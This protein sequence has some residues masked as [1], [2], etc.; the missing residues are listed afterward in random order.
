MQETFLQS[1][2]F[3]L[4]VIIHSMNVICLSE[5]ANKILKKN[6]RSQGYTLIEIKK[7]EAVYD[8]ISSH[9]DIYLCKI[10][11]ELVVA[12]AQ[13]PMIQEEL[14]RSGIKYSMGA[15]D[16][17]PSYPM[18]VSYNA[19]QVGNYLI[20]NLNHTDPVILNKAKEFG[21]KQILVKQGYTKCNLVV[22]NDHSAITSDPGLAAALNKNNLEILL[23]TQGHVHLTGFPYGF[24]GGASGRVGDEVI[25][26][27][28]L[29][30]HPDCD[31]II[32]FIRQRGLQVTFFKEYP[33]E[34]IGSIIQL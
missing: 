22:I 15:S 29:S 5:H 34:D 27:G 1:K 7:S 12:P 11:S 26:N 4:C 10:C 17:G 21:L 6:L 9:G 16:L 25:F 14:L 28:N 2:I 30:A 31:R 13:L 19:A 18:N 20:H 32:E 24:L 3:N 33:L 8:A 23:I